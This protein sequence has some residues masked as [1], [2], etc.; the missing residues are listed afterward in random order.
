M[1]KT[2]RPSVAM[3]LSPKSG[4]LL[5]EFER[6]HMS[7]APT[8]PT[9]SCTT[10]ILAV[11]INNY[12]SRTRASPLLSHPV[13]ILIPRNKAM[14]TRSSDK[15]AKTLNRN[16]DRV[17]LFVQPELEEVISLEDDSFPRSL[18][19][20]LASD[21]A[22]DEFL[23]DSRFY[24]LTQ[25]R[26]KLPSSRAKLLDGD[27]FTPFLKVF[28]SIL[29]HFWN[30][31]SVRNTRSVIDTHA[32]DIPHYEQGS[33]SLNTSRPSFIIKAEGPSFQLPY[34]RPGET[35]VDVGFSNV[36]AC[37]EIQEQRNE[38]ALSEQLTRV[39]IYAR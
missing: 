16:F 30:D 14:R 4:S 11:V 23:R 25:R 5:A 13:Y 22:V 33:D 10:T 36:A 34:T 27:F 15:K 8:L 32:T 29:Q 38:S 39:A 21:S 28:S 26:W 12:T 6:G 9:C 3:P 1:I 17:K 31:S 20:H 2:F 24:S 37:I 18:Y 35:P 19:H 7:F